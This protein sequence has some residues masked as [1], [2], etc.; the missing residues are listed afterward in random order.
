MALGL[1]DGIGYRDGQRQL[2]KAHRVLVIE[3]DSLLAMLLAETLS[4]LGHEVCAIAACE[5]DA[6]TAAT[7]FHPDLIIADVHLGHGSGIAAVTE[8]NR[9]QRIPHLFMSGNIAPAKA[10]RPNAVTLQKPFKEI[11][12]HNA[13]Q[14]ALR[15]APT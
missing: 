4:D 3:D 7:R 12:L 1:E 5:P 13:I 10:L 8:I 15:A 14:Q 9:T 11:D 2:L 6:A